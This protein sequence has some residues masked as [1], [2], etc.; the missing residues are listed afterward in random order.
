MATKNKLMRITDGFAS[1]LVK[2]EGGEAEEI[3]DEEGGMLISTIVRQYFMGLR[4][5]GQWA[6]LADHWVGVAQNAATPLSA[7]IILEKPDEPPS[8]VARTLQRVDSCEAWHRFL[9]RR[10]GL[11]RKPLNEDSDHDE[12]SSDDDDDQL[13]F[14]A[15]LMRK[16]WAR[17]VHK[18]GIKSSVCDPLKESEFVV[19]W[20]RV[21]AP[22]TE[23]R[24][25]MVGA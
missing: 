16:F 19:D 18:A 23:G 2:S 21:I 24:I 3:V 17:W 5:I 9:Q 12:D 10:I 1:L 25:K 14:D 6:N 22:V 4:T 8:S 15:L 13:D 20:T 11:H 7:S